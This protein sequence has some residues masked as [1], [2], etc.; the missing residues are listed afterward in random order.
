MGGGKTP[1]F[2]MALVVNTWS[3]PVRGLTL[4]PVVNN[5]SAALTLDL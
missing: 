3:T 2:T 1:P 5:L 4:R